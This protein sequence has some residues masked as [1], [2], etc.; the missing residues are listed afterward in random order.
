MV[1]TQDRTTL[2]KKS[3][4]QNY[5]TT[6]KPKPDPLAPLYGENLFNKT[7]PKDHPFRVL[8]KEIDWEAIREVLQGEDR[9]VIP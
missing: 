6:M 9:L 4:Y 5:R 8:L 3:K 7:I 2:L 1:L